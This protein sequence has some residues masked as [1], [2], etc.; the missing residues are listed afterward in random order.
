MTNKYKRSAL[1]KGKLKETAFQKSLL[2]AMDIRWFSEVAMC[3]SVIEAAGLPDNPLDYLVNAMKWSSDLCL[4]S[5]DIR[6]IQLFV[7]LL[8]PLAEKTDTL[9]ADKVSTI[10]LVYPCIKEILS[11]IKDFMEKNTTHVQFTIFCKDLKVAIEKRFEYVTAPK[12][13][14]FDPLYLTCTFLDPVLSEILSDDE[15]SVAKENLK[16]EIRKNLLKDGKSTVG[17]IDRFGGGN[18]PPPKKRNIRGFSHLSKDLNEKEKSSVGGS[19]QY[20]RDLTKYVA[21]CTVIRAGGIVNEK[22]SRKETDGDGVIV[23]EDESQNNNSDESEEVEEISL[24]DP[25][26]YWTNNKSKF[27][28]PLFEVAQDLLVIPATS[29]PCER[30]FSLA[31]VLSAGK[32]CKVGPALLERRVILKANLSKSKT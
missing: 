10:Q 27:E 29:T 1:A 8:E 26:G 17:V 23:I 21:D 30:L 11:H 9:G 3:K 12:S 13:N 6:N 22:G 18:E 14:S 4:N 32:F 25:L 5:A 15:K 2:G 31:G 7:G 19:T 24:K 16:A 20:L 28:S